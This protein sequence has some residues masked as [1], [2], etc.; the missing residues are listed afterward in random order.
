MRG[1]LNMWTHSERTP[2]KLL[3]LVSC[4]T[5]LAWCGEA[6]NL[7][8][9]ATAWRNLSH[10]W[11]NEWRRHAE[12]LDGTPSSDLNDVNSKEEVSTTT[13]RIVGG[14]MRCCRVVV[15]PHVSR[16]MY[17]V[18]PIGT[19]QQGRTTNRLLGSVSCSEELVVVI[20]DCRLKPVCQLKP[21]NS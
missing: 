2:A 9:D 10:G 1:K 17:I 11:H 12:H 3:L 6:Q 21:K 16:C 8:P 5:F 18:V 14:S 19:H 7:G 20:I 15:C 13:C 4:T